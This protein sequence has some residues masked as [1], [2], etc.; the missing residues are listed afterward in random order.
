MRNRKV[1]TGKSTQA[2]LHIY[3]CASRRQDK[4]WVKRFMDRLMSPP[5]IGSTA[6]LQEVTT[7]V[8]DRVTPIGSQSLICPKFPALQRDTPPM[9]STI[10]PYSPSY[11]H[12]LPYPVFYP[13]PSLQPSLVSILFTLLGEIQ[14]SSLGLSLLHSFFESVDCNM[15]I[16]YFMTIVYLWVH[17]LCVFLG[18]SYLTLV[19]WLGL[20]PHT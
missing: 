16:L 8:S 1:T 12:S 19:V 9:I 7:S 4:L 10:S 14:A 2:L 5:F 11:P 17:T 6:W 13:V 18:L 20:A 15:F 3:S